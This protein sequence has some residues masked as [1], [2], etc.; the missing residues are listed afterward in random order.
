MEA[1][2]DLKDIYGVNVGWTGSAWVSVSFVSA[3]EAVEVGSRI[4]NED[5]NV[6]RPETQSLKAMPGSGAIEMSV[7]WEQRTED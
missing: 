1:R 7:F 6:G 2:Q 5:M 4:S 3:L